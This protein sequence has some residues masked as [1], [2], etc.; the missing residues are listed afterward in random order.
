MSS[1]I[2]LFHF[3]CRERLS[4]IL[5]E[6]ITK[7]DV[8]IS[9]DS[10]FQAPSLT[11][12]CRWDRQN[13]AHP[14]DCIVNKTAVRLLV[15]I[16]SD[17][18]KLQSWHD[19]AVQYEMDRKWLKALAGNDDD[20]KWYIYNGI[21]TPDMIKAVDYNPSLPDKMPEKTPEDYLAMAIAEMNSELML[22]PYYRKFQ[23]EFKD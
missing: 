23:E 1:T 22:E 19:V 11:G 18:P 16:A 6:G 21:I 7:G 20:Q 3:T 17:D 9:P 5:E 10:G 15:E 2:T 12:D 14:R 13:W 8:A 4:K